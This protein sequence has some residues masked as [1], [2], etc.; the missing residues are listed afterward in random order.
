MLLYS[1]LLI[2]TSLVALVARPQPVKVKA[3]SRTQR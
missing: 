3:T 1:A 2:L